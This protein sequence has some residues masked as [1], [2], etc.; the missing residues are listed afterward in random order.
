MLVPWWVALKWLKAPF[1]QVEPNA[2]SGSF[3][4]EEEASAWL[5]RL[6]PCQ[7]ALTHQRY[8]LCTN[9]IFKVCPTSK[10][11]IGNQNQLERINELYNAIAL[12]GRVDGMEE[13]IRTVPHLMFDL[14]LLIRKSWN[15]C[16]SCNYFS[17]HS[18]PFSI[19]ESKQG[20]FR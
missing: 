5:V 18:N 8:G 12:V 6:L 2:T 19:P 9:R 16:I 17:S 15:H 11:W 4:G 20:F 10:A 3:Q 14:L 13:D 7:V 1:E